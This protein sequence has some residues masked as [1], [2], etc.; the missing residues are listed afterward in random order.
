M[1]ETPRPSTLGEILDRTAQ[2]Y[3]HS[4]WLF[5]GI[6]ALPI[7]VMIAALVPVGVVWAFIFKSVNQG[8]RPDDYQ[9]VG[10]LSVGAVALFLVAIPAY[11]AAAI[12]SMGGLTHAA[13]GA[14]RGEKPTIRGALASVRPWFWRY[15]WYAILQGIYVALIPI[16]IAVAL[17]A[18]L[19]YLLSQSG[20]GVGA[21]VAAGF[22]VFLVFAGAVGA[23]VWRGLGY[24][25]GF[26]VCVAEQ[27][28]ASQSLSR[29]WQLS[30]GSRG[31]ICVMFLLVAALAFAVSMAV[32]IP[33][34]IIVAILGAQGNPAEPST[35]FIVAEIVRVVVDFTIQ[36]L[37]APVSWIALVL[38]YFDQRI[39]K[40]GFDIEWMM[41][42]AGLA[43]PPPGF[44]PA[45]ILGLEPLGPVAPPS[46]AAGISAP[47]APPDTVEER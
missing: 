38:F 32:S 40:E 23:I 12:F 21:G 24:S 22:L 27:K 30:H 36:A 41:Q 42:Q 35:A 13:V 15:L 14:Y 17:A 20:E 2:I 29:A 31:R 16:A 19:F 8:M 33:F 11:I 9:Q 45:G 47:A 39:R 6:G 25:M 43:P 28:T 44:A 46:G 1:N 37:L 10:L 4:F 18:P 5:A 26:A 7:G 34:L 3:R